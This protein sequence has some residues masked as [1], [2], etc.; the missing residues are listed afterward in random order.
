MQASTLPLLQIC[1]GAGFY[2]K[3]DPTRRCNAR[4]MSVYIGHSLPPLLILFVIVVVHDFLVHCVPF[5]LDSLRFSPFGSTVPESFPFCVVAFGCHP[6]IL[7]LEY[8]REYC[9]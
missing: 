3:G 8:L 1:H 2:F 5:P 9:V 7:D 4:L 6:I